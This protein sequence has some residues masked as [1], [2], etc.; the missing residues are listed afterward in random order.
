MREANRGENIPGPDKTCRV[1]NRAVR[2]GTTVTVV[3]ITLSF[4][5]LVASGVASSWEQWIHGDDGHWKSLERAKHRKEI[6]QRIAKNPSDA[7]AWYQLSLERG[8]E[9][10]FRGQEQALLKAMTID[11]ANANYRYDYVQSLCSLERFC[12][13]EAEIRLHQAG[14]SQQGSASSFTYGYSPEEIA[15]GCREERDRNIHLPQS[16]LR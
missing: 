5:V 1:R 8:Y 14:G 13:A 15:R 2:I 16:G 12:D 4:L 10:D 3:C 9:G 11:P 6:Q 7:D